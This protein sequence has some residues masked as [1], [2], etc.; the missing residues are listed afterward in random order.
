MTPRPVAISLRAVEKNPEP[1]TVAVTDFL[2]GLRLTGSERVLGALSLVLAESMDAARPLRRAGSL[3]NCARSSSSYRRPSSRRAT[4]TCS[5]ASSCEEEQ[6]DG[7]GAPGRGFTLPGRV[8]R[9]RARSDGRGDRE[10]A[11]PVARIRQHLPWRRP[12]TRRRLERRDSPLPPSRECLPRADDELAA[13]IADA[14]APFWRHVREALLL[15][16]RL[17]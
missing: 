7:R 8:H 12:C 17:Q 10:Q 16:Q 2:G 11:T 5:S 6:G 15:Q 13:Q 1:I 9:A 4:A 3:T 14:P